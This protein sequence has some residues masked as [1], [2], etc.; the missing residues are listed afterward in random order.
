MSVLEYRLNNA[1]LGIRMIDEKIN[2]CL[3]QLPEASQLELQNFAEF[4]L[5]K[6]AKHET[7]SKYKFD[8]NEF[9][10]SMALSDIDEEQLSTYSLSD[11]KEVFFWE[12]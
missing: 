6:I 2:D 3:K 7:S 9:S 5:S 11:L 10:L 1:E 8:W 4:L 12:D